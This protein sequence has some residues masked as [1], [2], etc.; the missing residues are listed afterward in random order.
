MAYLLIHEE[1]PNTSQLA[2]YKTGLKSMRGIPAPVKAVLEQ[3]PA[4]AHP[5]D[6]LRTGVSVQALLGDGAYA[7]GRVFGGHARLA[8]AHS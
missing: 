1:M 4:A 2:R 3:I 5:M 6:V 7:L 8:T